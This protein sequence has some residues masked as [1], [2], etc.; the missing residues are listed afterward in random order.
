[1]T[2]K[3][4]AYTITAGLVLVILV[5]CSGGWNIFRQFTQPVSTPVNIPSN[6]NVNTNTT[7]SSETAPNASLTIRLSEGQAQPQSV[8]ALPAANG[9]P[10]SPEEIQAILSRLEPLDL[11]SGAQV[12]FNLP[13]DPIPP[14][15]PGSTLEQPFPQPADGSAPPSLDSG[16]LKVLRHAPDGEVAVAPFIH[17][18]F[19]QPMVP[20]GTLGDLSLLDVPVQVEPALP[21][22]W[23]WLGT[24]TLTFSYDS[25]LI[26]RLPKATR[27]TVRIPAGT[28]SATGGE[29]AETVEWTFTTPAPQITSSYPNGTPQPRNPLIFIAFDQRIDPA[30]MLGKIELRAGGSL[31]EIILASQAEVE[32]SESIKNLA[33]YTPEGRWLAFR[34]AAELPAA[35]DIT[36]SVL[37]G[38]PSAEGPLTTQADQ[39]FSFYTYAPLKVESQNCSG[40]TDACRPLEP[41]YIN[42]NN[43]IDSE[44]YSDTML[45]VSPEI[46]G[47]VVNIYGTSLEIRGATRGQTTYTVT[48]NENL[49]DTFGQK[50]GHSEKLTFWVGKAEPVLIGPDQPFVTVD[51]AAI[52][53]KPVFSVYTI[54]YNKLEVK[55]YAVQPSDWPGFVNYLANW[56]YTDKPMPMPGRIVFD[57]T[58]GVESVTDNLTQ[59]DIDLSPYLDGKYG[60]F[61]V[62]VR[63]PKGLFEKEQDMYWRTIHSWVQISGIGLDAFSDL[64]QM[65]VWTTALKDGA[66]LADVTIT[67]GEAQTTVATGADG[68]A[69][70]P[71]PQ[72][73]TYLSAR[74]GADTAILPRSPYAYYAN[75]W[76][77]SSISDELRWY[78]FDDRQMYRPGEDVH[79]KGWIRQLGSQQDG[80]VGLASPSLAS[81]N[82]QLN[83]W[84]GNQ[85]A[86]GLAEVNALGGFDFSLTLPTEVNLGQVQLILSANG[87]G[88]VSNASYYH[89]FQIQEFRRPEFEVSARNESSGPYFAGG[90][91]T[92]A[93][94]AKYYAGGALPGA[95]TNWQV[96]YAPGSYTPPNWP[97]FTFGEWTPWWSYRGIS[98]FYDYGGPTSAGESQSFS[99][100]TDAAGVHYL[101]LDFDLNSP[102]EGAFLRPVSVL[103][104]ATVMDVNRQAWSSSTSLLVHPASLYIGMRSDRY[105][106]ERGTP[107]KVDFIVTDLDGNA[108]TDRPVEISAA[109]MEWKLTKG[110]WAEE[111]VDVQTCKLGSGLTPLTCVFETPIGGSYKITAQVKDEQGR[112]NQSSFTRWVSGGQIPPA[113]KVEQEKVTL[114]PDKQTY[115]P[116]DTAQILVQSPFSP[117][118]GLLTVSRSGVLYTQR[119]QIQ[120][121]AATLSIPIE[122]KYLPNLELQVD[123]VGAAPRTSDSGE[124]LPNAEPRP[125][126][127]SGTLHLSIPAL[128][129]TLN[130]QAVP[131][132]TRL[133]PGGQTT[134]NLTLLDAAGLPVPDAELAVVVVDEAILALSNYTQQD[135]ISVF[136]SDR[137]AYFDS[138]Y[139][140][141]SLVLLNPNALVVSES[142]QR[143]AMDAAKTVEL[144]NL[145]AGA[146]MAEEAMPAAMPM[147]TATAGMNTGSAAPNTP[148]A[149]RAN[150]NPLATFAPAVHTDA[151]GQASVAITLPDNLTRYRIMVVAVDSSGRRF[152][153]AE[154]NL[155][156]RLPLMVRPSAPRFLNFGD[157]FELPVVLQNQTD[158][159]L[160]VSVVARAA[161]LQVGS[162]PAGEAL[163]T[164]AGMRV[165]VPANQRIEVRFPA[166]TDRAG[167]ARI[168]V[169][170]VS[171]E[172]ADAAVVE[173]PVY[174]P[175]TTEAFATYGVLDEGAVAQPLLT[176]T[177][178]FPQYGGLEINASST[179]LQA[180]TDA[181]LYLQSYP[182]ECSEQLSSRIL[183]VAALRDV[184]TA[185]Q[186]E[187]LPSPAD[188][189]FALARDITRLE[190]LQNNDGGFPYWRRGFDSIPF[191]T[192]HVTHALVRARQKG[193]AVPD[194]MFYSALSYLADI[195]SHYPAEYSESTRRTLSAYALYVRDLS[196]DT[197]AVKATN[198]LAKD[199]LEAFSL[200]AIGWLWPV[201]Q[202][203]P[204]SIEK[205]REIRAYV[206]NR[207][208]ET[209]GAANF[210]TSYDDQSYLLLGSD[211]RTDAILLDALITDDPNSDLIP[212]LVTGLLAHRVKGRWGSTQ[213]NVFVLLALDH[214]F[215]TFESQTPDFVA[216]LW[217]GD[218]YAGSFQF[219]GRS[220]ERQEL[221]IP[222]AYLVDPA[223]GQNQ[224]LILSKDGPG[225]LYYRLGLR[226]APT[227]LSLPA[228]DMGFVVQRR[229]EAVD[230]PAD[231]SQDASGVWHIRAGARVR[232]VITM[233]ADNRRNHVA[234]VDPLP[235]GLE[236]VNP[237][238]AVSAG[239]APAAETSSRYLWWWWTWYQHQNMRDERAEAFTS[240]LWEGVYEYTYIAR[241]TTP[242]QFVVPPAKAEEMYS[243]EVFGRSTS[244]TVIVK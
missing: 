93:V 20:L 146:P 226:Y 37:A 21:G 64:E 43:P 136:Y 14:T 115:Q 237:A 3:S 77:T 54:N 202:K 119:F 108:V 12:D 17:I 113:R 66:P 178:V 173:L 240:L 140:R 46:P 62:V 222:M 116:G 224:N 169:A 234:L 168:Q 232:V 68:T 71:I 157:Q 5:A 90:S 176:P 127:A 238:L 150:F 82:Y 172:Y 125:A 51:P 53:K 205:L 190:G 88:S 94:E 148:I 185:F 130:L 228:L 133:T 30:A 102:S 79:I 97:D 181:M 99:G 207:A 19:N 13:G 212:K 27:Y 160:E 195:E 41:F 50:L 100:Q 213:E 162:E 159:D 131:E 28:K 187:G 175:A 183:S 24:K 101:Q 147:A 22:I 177:G 38:A 221:N 33:K 18:T 29:L 188:M 52:G 56:Q 8:E 34:A 84:D 106:V 135:P 109:R 58:I 243:P 35:T 208:V 200:D 72:G 132:V 55:I 197:D 25:T 111:A 40:L 47:V 170:A 158:S 110:V 118:E 60:H 4:I 211:R 145:S 227:S 75:A 210:T 124:L 233:E 76:Q 137:P 194:E 23:R 171:G 138:V 156:A 223:A 36:V 231:V 6:T 201:M 44:I 26:D 164:S 121:G 114:I 129:R 161:N 219:Q 65:T 89:S 154:A 149:V 10:L 155:T 244:D 104:S 67:A 236:I 215:N 15:L 204:E 81:V 141:A 199:K 163:I 139:S 216:R 83:G 142:T 59:V 61:I 105:F 63:P 16:P 174:T 39:T 151:A 120:D 107:I 217:L 186:A 126:Y 198:L 134:L 98:E 7:I 69:R 45:S 70:L 143:Q 42:F 220:T 73:A 241:A 165:N 144:E 95:E 152:G 57:K 117:A 229:Y 230:D 193:Y 191:N 180:L 239:Q 92:L 218:T 31:A 203:T 189:E 209:A 196:G 179:A 11:E 167:F 103:A 49:Q 225:R 242:G 2:K 9:E 184:L 74:L 85:I 96:T 166:T 32:A 128:V 206:E 1:M 235:A 182:F 87:A 78:V 122:E 80:D 214:Y 123:L 86:N 112:L 91:A 48:I 192:I 153:Q